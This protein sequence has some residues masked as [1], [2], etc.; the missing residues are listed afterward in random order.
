MLFALVGNV[1]AYEIGYWEYYNEELENT[2]LALYIIKGNAKYA[3]N[4]IDMT[5]HGTN[6]TSDQTGS[7]NFP[8]T[9]TAE[10]RTVTDIIYDEHGN[11]VN[12]VWKY[13]TLE[14]TVTSVS[15][16]SSGITSVS[17]PNTVEYIGQQAFSGCAALKTVSSS[18]VKYIHWGAFQNCPELET[19]SAANSVVYIGREAFAYCPKFKHLNGVISIDSIAAHA[20]R[21]CPSLETVG[22]QVRHVGYEAFAGCEK[23]RTFFT[24]MECIRESAFAGCT[25]LAAASLGSAKY[26]GEDA[27]SGCTALSSEIF[28]IAENVG[29]RA[30]YNCSAIPKVHINNTVKY[31]GKNAFYGCTGMEELTFGENSE[32]EIGN[33]AFQ[34]CYGLRDVTIRGKIIGTE[35]F[36]DCYDET[37]GSGAPQQAVDNYRKNR[38]NTGGTGLK[39]VTID[40]S[41]K[42]IKNEAFYGCRLLET[43]TI[44]NSVDT[45]EQG[46]FFNCSGLKG[47]LTFPSSVKFLGSSAC[48]GCGMT[49]VVLSPSLEI[50]Q[51]GTF[52]EC[53]NLESID[54]PAKVRIIDDRAFYKCPNL[55]R[56]T[57]IGVDSIGTSAF[58][59]C[60][61]LTNVAWGD[62]LRII[63]NHAFEGCTNI[64]GKMNF[65]KPLKYI[66]WKNFSDCKK[67]TGVSFPDGLETIG[68][69]AFY[70][71]TGISQLTMPNSLKGVGPKAFYNCWN[72]ES[73]LEFPASL[74]YLGEGAFGNCHKL[75]GI[76]LGSASNLETIESYAFSGC[77]GIKGLVSIPNGVTS[78]K[79]EAF[80]GCDS[81]NSLHIGASLQEIGIDAFFATPCDNLSTITVSNSNSTYDSRNNCNAM[82]ATSTNTLIKGCYRTVIPETVTAI[83]DEAFAG[84]CITGNFNIPDAVTTI[85]KSAFLGCDGITSIGLSANNSLKTIGQWAFRDCDNMTDTLQLPSIVSVGL[86]AFMYCGI[87]AV[88]FGNQL[89]SLEPQAFLSYDLQYVTFKSSTPPTTVGNT[90]FLYSRDIPMFIPN[91]TTDAYKE[92]MPNQ[93]I[94]IEEGENT[95]RAV[96]ADPK[97][98]KVNFVSWKNENEEITEVTIFAE[99]ERGHKFVSW[100]DGNTENPRTI[101]VTEDLNLVAYFEALDY[102]V[103]AISNNP[104]M[105]S[106]KGGGIHK[107]GTEATL[108][109]EPKDGYKF[110]EWQDGNTDNPRTFVVLC[111][112]TFTARFDVADG[113]Y[114]NYLTGV[115]ISTTDKGVVIDNAQGKS[116]SIYNLTGQLLVKETSITTNNFVVRIGR[117]GIYLVKVGDDQVQKVIVF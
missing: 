21:Q 36:R 107:Y 79:R 1:A 110:K 16:G 22:G 93:K 109:A 102:E 8:P 19:V 94:F 86:G 52:Y 35:A 101:T 56:V 92:K 11:V 97:S 31:I 99:P 96:S 83:G 47:T 23:L 72:I 90:A 76:D 71:C 18:S 27:F 4:N 114:E 51:D 9:I 104:N 40:N 41:V 28:I 5:V 2:D 64:E 30:F 24:G 80:Y 81:I 38:G 68:W 77:G 20:F 45:I 63:G 89:T 116:L 100:S 74:T 43:I 54:I 117:Q 84:C 61:A 98:G 14:Y 33:C 15:L 65:P 39:N 59:T 111:D 44:G 95:V 62:S 57:M 29:Q 55:N 75:S 106:V 12:Y 34:G 53:P 91:G 112:T 46:A 113:I 82:I 60:T 25:S 13:G 26:I 85:G 10:I 17:I 105:G 67:I 58:Y 50:I 103:T 7:I 42:T 70:G 48:W 37:G 6:K 108:T 87:P 73:K 32:L 69:E 78:I 115:V 49:N 66:G 88:V 3:I